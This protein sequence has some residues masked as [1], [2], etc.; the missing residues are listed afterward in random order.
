MSV[1][2]I[3]SLALTS[4]ASPDSSAFD[5]FFWISG[6]VL[7][8]V[9]PKAAILVRLE[10]PGVQREIYGQLDTG[11]D[12]TIFYGN[13]LRKHG[14]D[15]DSSGSVPLQ[16]QW[17]DYGRKDS[18]L[19]TPA[20]IDWQRDSDRDL[21]SDD[22]GHHIVG[23]IG[24][25]KL[26]GKILILDFRR[27]RYA[28]IT[29]TLEIRHLVPR[30]IGYVDAQIAYNKFFVSVEMGP[31]TLQAVR[32]DTGA[33]AFTL[34]LPR[35]WWQWATGLAGTEREVE[36]DTVASWGRGVETWTARS[37]YALKFGPVI[38]PAPE[39]TYIN[40]PDS[41]MADLKLIGNAPFYDNHVVVVD[42]I[43]QKFGVSRPVR[44]R[45]RE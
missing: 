34:V 33:S 28:V 14:I 3:L 12:A 2:L 13:I 36:R 44:T 35:D 6:D 22:P 37:K 8:E 43:R 29:D 45:D 27:S 24:L 10:I 23:S 39:V 4:I 20:F 7:G 16:F 17:Y 38:I 25:D 21:R 15:V 31:D 40:W 32:Y 19:E 18:P 5:D 42:C 9:N 11:S 41:T 1:F 26:I 30:P